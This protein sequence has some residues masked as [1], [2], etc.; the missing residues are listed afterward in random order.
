MRPEIE[1]QTTLADDDELK[2]PFAL[3]ILLGVGREYSRPAETPFS[4]CEFLHH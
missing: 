2:H 3:G 4:M 1:N